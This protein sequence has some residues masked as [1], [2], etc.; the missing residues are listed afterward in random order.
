MN[1][2]AI[3]P[4]LLFLGFLIIVVWQVLTLYG[5]KVERAQIAWILLFGLIG[6]SM[7]FIHAIMIRKGKEIRWIITMNAALLSSVI[8]CIW[9]MET[10]LLHR[11]IQSGKY[12][13]NVA[14]VLAKIEF[15]APDL[16]LFI[17]QVLIFTLVIGRWLAPKHGDY[18]LSEFSSSLIGN[19]AVGA[20]A[21]ELLEAFQ[22]DEK[23]SENETAVFSIL[24]IW[25]LSLITFA[26]D[27][28]KKK[29]RHDLIIGSK[30]KELDFIGSSDS[31]NLVN[32]L[33]D[34]TLMH[35]EILVILVN[36]CLLEVPYLILRIVLMSAYGFYTTS[37]LFFI[38]KNALMCFLQTYHVYSL[39]Q[40]LPDHRQKII[41]EEAAENQ[42]QHRKQARNSITAHL[43]EAI[44]RI[45]RPKES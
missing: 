29:A 43:L 5:T 41:E 35:S 1:Y 44:K 27:I 28:P 33:L 3:L 16:V 34:G 36:L 12:E 10:E 7:E 6:V 2:F 21:L 30:Y 17:E 45:R 39:F 9:L 20:D 11:R 4:R 19:L 37:A 14:M 31:K 26:I 15:E 42:A 25:S 40:T 22:N 8:P 23:L 13:P 24:A 32:Q 18:D 38:L